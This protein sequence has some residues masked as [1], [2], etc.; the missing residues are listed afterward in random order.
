MIIWRSSLFQIADLKRFGRHG[1]LPVGLVTEHC[2]K[3]SNNVHNPEYEAARTKQDKLLWSFIVH[4]YTKNTERAYV[5]LSPKGKD[6]GGIYQA[7]LD[8]NYN[9]D[10]ISLF[11]LQNLKNVR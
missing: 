7:Q 11:E 6:L 3:V 4:L 8:S 5:D 9:K 10:T 2:P 1:A